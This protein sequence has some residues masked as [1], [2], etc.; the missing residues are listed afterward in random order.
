[1]TQ[2]LN[3]RLQL[4]LGP[5]PPL[6]KYMRPWIELGDRS[7]H[8]KDEVKVGLV[9]KYTR[10]ED[11]YTSLVKALQHAGIQL[12]TKVV[13]TFIEASNLEKG[14]LEDN[15]AGYHQ[16]WHNLCLCE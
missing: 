15:P 2:Y 8:L 9:G 1:M 10:L 4:G 12:G 7:S 14:M 13:I 3:D 11:S 16:A 6:R 5:L